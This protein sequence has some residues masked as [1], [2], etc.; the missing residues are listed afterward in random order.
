MTKVI[1]QNYELQAETLDE[2]IAEVIEQLQTQ[3]DSSDLRYALPS[4]VEILSY[5]MSGYQLTVDFSE[6]YSKLKD[7]EEV[8][9]RAE[10][11]Y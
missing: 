2:Q 6:S 10:S 7:S 8:L 11:L 3:P 1:P 4:D 9:V 5:T